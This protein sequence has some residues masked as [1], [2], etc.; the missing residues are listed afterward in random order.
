MNHLHLVLQRN[1][2]LQSLKLFETIERTN[3]CERKC[4][5]VTVNFPKGIVSIEGLSER[6]NFE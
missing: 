1:I 5:K 2:F 3:S 6:T 4:C